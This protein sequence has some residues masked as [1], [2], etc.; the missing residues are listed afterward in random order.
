[1]TTACAGKFTPQAKVEVQHRTLP[2]CNTNDI[3][4]RAPYDGIGAATHLDAIRLEHSFH[5]VSVTSQHSCMMDSKP[6]IEK[7]LHFLVPRRCHLSSEE[8]ELRMRSRVKVIRVALHLGHLLQLLRSLDRI[9]SRMNKHH[10]L[11][12]CRKIFGHLVE[13]SLVHITF[14]CVASDFTSDTDEVLLKGNG[15]EGGVEE[16]ESLVPVDSVQKSSIHQVG[17]PENTD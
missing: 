11:M 9:L 2:E 17:E 12:P 15:T 10:D 5:H 1:M 7:L 8:V 13:H 6:I 14:R 4:M 3:R 16:E